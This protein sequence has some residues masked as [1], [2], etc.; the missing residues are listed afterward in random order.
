MG[1]IRLFDRS[2]KTVT[3]AI[4]DP[5]DQSAI[6]I[7]QVLPTQESRHIFAIDLG[8]GSGGQDL[9]SEFS[10]VGVHGNKRKRFFEDCLNRYP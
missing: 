6:A 1:I 8:N 2:Q 5:L 7:V 10:D 4:K 9:S 3:N